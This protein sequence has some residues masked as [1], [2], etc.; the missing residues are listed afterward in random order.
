[1]RE[2]FRRMPETVRNAATSLASVAF[3]LFWVGT[4]L[5]LVHLSND[6]RVLVYPRVANGTNGFEDREFR[7]EIP[8]GQFRVLALGASAFVTREFQPRFESRLAAD[9]LFRRRGLSPRVVSTGVPAHTSYDSLWKYRYWYRGYDFDL[10]IFYHGI[11][12]ARANNYPREVFREDYTQFPYYQRYAPAFAWVERHG[13]LARSFA[14][15]LGVSLYYR[16]KVLFAP[17]FQREAPYNH[18]LDDPWLAEGADLKTPP[19]FARNV[20]EVLRIARE[21]G[22]RVLLLTYA[23]HLPADYTNERFLAGQTDYTFAPE[24]VATEVWG[25]KEN[26]IAAI[27]AHNAEIRRLAAAHPEALFFDMER[28]LPK[29]G[30]HFIDVCHWTDLGREAFAQGVLEAMA[31]QEPE[32]FA[33]G[34]AR[35]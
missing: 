21:R 27:E 22:Q 29:D 24:S 6:P 26:V 23:Y 5:R 32:L 14:A 31:R 10:V 30:R 8:P 4:G 20:E 28:R 3:A 19:V 35:G 34:L 18:P 1:M 9:P 13:L 33:R 11:N 15:T 17:A 2:L 12:D 16:A 25:R 7:R